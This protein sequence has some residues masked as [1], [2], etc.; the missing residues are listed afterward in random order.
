MG[1]PLER[2]GELKGK[3]LRVKTKHS[4]KSGEGIGLKSCQRDIRGSERK[5]CKR[6]RRSSKSGGEKERG[7]PV[8][9]FQRILQS[10]KGDRGLTAG[11]SE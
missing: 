10:N 8:S 9:R 6:M 2:E 7:A 5:R 11:K 4:A 3:G 1:Q